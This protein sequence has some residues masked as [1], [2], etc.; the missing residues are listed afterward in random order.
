MSKYGIKIKNFEAATVFGCNIGTRD[1]LESTDAMLTNSLFLDFLKDNG[2]NVWKESSTRD[3]I[4]LEFGYGAPSYDKDKK[5]HQNAIKKIK[6]D[7]KLTGEEKKKKIAIHELLIEK[8]EENKD[9]YVEKSRNDL[10]ILFYTEG[11]SITYKTYNNRG[12]IIKEE[13]IHYKMLYRTPGKAKK[14]TCMFINE[15][16]YDK[17]HE[18]LYMGI[19]LPKK[20]SPIVEIGAYASLITSSI[21]GKVQIKPE[22]MLIVK[23]VPTNMTT[24]AILVKTNDKKQCIT[25]RVDSYN[26]TGEAF[27]GQAL[28]D[29][30][31]FPEWGNGFILLRHHMT[32]CAAFNTNIIGF[33]KDQYGDEYETATVKDMFGRDV[34]VKDIRFITTN[35]AIKWLKFGVSIDYWFEWVKK[36]DCMFGIVKTCHESKLGDVQRMSYQ[37]TNSLNIDTM[38]SVVEKSVTYIE[39]LKSNNEQY[40]LDYLKQNINFSNDYEVLLALVEHNPEFVR[41]E[42]YRDRKRRIID[43]YVLDFKG[44]R[45]VQ[46]ADNLTI[47]GSPYAMLLHSIGKDPRKDPTFKLESD[48]I[49]CWCSKFRDNEY[50]AEFRS[51][52]N[53][54]NNL[55][56]IHNCYHEYWDKYFKL[57]NLCLAI[58]TMDT[59]WQPRNNGADQDSD[60]CYTTN[61]PDIVAHAKYCYQNYPTVVNEIQPEKNIYDL[62]LENYAKIDNNLT[63]CQS[64]IG[65]SSNLAQIALTYTYNF[66]NTKYDDYVCI[67][68]VLA[69]VAIDNAKRKFDVELDKEINRIKNELD[70]D[71]N[72]LPSFWLITKKDKRK[73]KSDKERKER[74]NANKNKIKAKLNKNLVCPM[75]YLYDLK[76]KYERDNQS[77]LPMSYFF[78]KHELNEHHRKSKKVEELIQ[79]YS[80]KLH[81]YYVNNDGVNWIEDN[82]DNILVRTD[83]DQLIE[84]IRL[85]YI[86]KN[87]LGLMSWLINRAFC[88]GIGAKSKSDTM[89][90][91]LD[92]NKSLLMKVLYEVNKDAFLACFKEK[93]GERLEINV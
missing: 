2:L 75:N 55:G 4:C 59:D 60:S 46:N 71:I 56:Y 52:F 64:A 70:I 63:A 89:N 13:T 57:G 72:G 17:A 7:D 50:L 41:S 58:N 93:S 31:L 26:L 61:Q 14:G 49:Q 45:T 66:N 22:Q 19:E 24:S 88:I 77:T 47:V 53:S 43:A 27:D 83:F 85:V 86:S 30:S 74:Q 21:I 37:M 29:Y 62:S 78:I 1:R 79:N 73:A 33:L 39:N 8:A 48:S 87:Y 9:K 42:Y 36:N 54:R 40:F 44:G 5:T 68:A 16:L 80:F 23:D 67:L 82:D 51:P 25:E 20:N 32:K 69:Q 34:K 18:F 10:R 81:N 65:Q 38:P 6:I 35:N 28:I 12:K 84:D 90:S 3:V 76:L 92:K 11:V 91:N 15:V